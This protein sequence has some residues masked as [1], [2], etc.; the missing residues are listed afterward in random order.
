[1]GASLSQPLVASPSARAFS[2]IMQSVPLKKKETPIEAVVRVAREQSQVGGGKRT[3]F[4]FFFFSSLFVDS[5]QRAYLK[6]SIV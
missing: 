2:S 6:A 5:S 4:F 3:F 1:L